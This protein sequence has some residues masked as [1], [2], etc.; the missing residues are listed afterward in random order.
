MWGLGLPLIA[1][2]LW[3]TFRVPND[4]G[5]APVAVPGIL[6]LFLELAYFGAASWALFASGQPLWG[7]GFAGLV[8]FHYLI[9]YDRILWLLRQPAPEQ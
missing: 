9:S 1:A 3:G 6:R 2:V 4:P 7:Y 8:L 5:K